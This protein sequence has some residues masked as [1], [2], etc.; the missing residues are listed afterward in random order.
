MPLDYEQEQELTDDQTS[1]E[2]PVESVPEAE[3]EAEPVSPP[4]DERRFTQADVDR[5]VKERLAKDRARRG[6]NSPADS[7][8]LQES[9][10]KLLK[11]NQELLQ[12]LQEEKQLR[13][14]A[15]QKLRGYNA[16]S[17]LRDAILQV[18]V[19]DL[20]VAE[21]FLQDAITNDPDGNPVLNSPAGKKL[22]INVDSVSQLIP[23]SLKKP[24]VTGGSGSFAT[25]TKHNH[26]LQAEERKLEELRRRASANP[27]DNYL[28]VEHAKQRRLVA[29]LKKGNR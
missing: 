24:K 1:D 7:K 6:S 14:A 29:Q 12:L 22:P 8:P 11:Q 19:T 25:T 2:T 15:E 26:R 20:H 10:A 3:P 5:I 9:N 13:E 28:L 17:L 18:G 4:P 21:K 16:Q 27:N 23:D